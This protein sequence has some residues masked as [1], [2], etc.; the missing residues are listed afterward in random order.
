M[1]RRPSSSG[2]SPTASA[3]PR[4]PATTLVALTPAT[5]AGTLFAP[6]F[7]TRQSATVRQDTMEIRRLSARSVSVDL[8]SSTPSVP[9]SASDTSRF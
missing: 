8:V 3:R 9:K 5:A 2:V 6:S 7:S 4:R 1:Q